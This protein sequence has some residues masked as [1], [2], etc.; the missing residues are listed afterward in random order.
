MRRY[1]FSYMPTKCIKS[2]RM[3]KTKHMKHTIPFC[4]ESN[5][6]GRYLVHNNI[7]IC[8]CLQLFR[9]H[10]KNSIKIY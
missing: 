8:N 2:F 10:I 4:I 1:V 7:N 5:S 3:P 6:P 9:I